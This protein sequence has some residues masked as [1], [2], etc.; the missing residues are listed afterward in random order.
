MA[1]CWGLLASVCA[2]VFLGSSAIVAHA[3]E[4]GCVLFSD[5]IPDKQYHPIKREADGSY[6]NKKGEDYVALKTMFVGPYGWGVTDPQVKKPEKSNRRLTNFHKAYLEVNESGSLFDSEQTKAVLQSIE[7]ISAKNSPVYAVIYIHGWHHNANDDVDLN[8]PLSLNNNTVKFNYFA[9]RYAEQTRRLFELNK[10]DASPAI[11]AIYVGWRGE[12]MPGLLTKLTIG[13]RAQVADTIG[14]ARG[15][16]TLR[17]ALIDI[18]EKVRSTGDDGRTLIVGHSLGGRM[19]SRMVLGD[20]SV[21]NFQP[22]GKNVLFTAIQPA[23]GA[24]CYD[25]IFSAKVKGSKNSP[26]SFIAFTSQDDRALSDIYPWATYSPVAPPSCNDS[27][28]RHSTIGNYGAYITHEF[29]FNHAGEWEKPKPYPKEVLAADGSKLKFPLIESEKNWLYEAGETVWSYPYHDNKASEKHRWL[30]YELRSADIYSLKIGR[31]DAFDLGGAV[32][33]I[34]TDKNLIDVAED[35][36][37]TEPGELGALH[38]AI[39][40]TGVA[41]ILSRIVYAQRVWIESA[42]IVPVS[43][44]KSK[45]PSVPEPNVTGGSKAS[46]AGN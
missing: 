27:S 28:R 23:I 33:N 41:D 29:S 4:S 8:D 39:A 44:E 35:S 32:W 25:Q 22:F 45:L 34:G 12:S 7:Q 1:S 26:P 19:L 38:N 24:D 30:E 2:L 20:I 6:K 40:S 42:P 21:G 37:H 14:N 11:L 31:K 43:P 9:A 5:C 15:P 10:N 3:A 18:A 46:I 36:K 17:Q 16:K 13:D